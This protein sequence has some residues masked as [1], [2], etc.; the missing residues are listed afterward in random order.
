MY[1]SNTDYFYGPYLI[2]KCTHSPVFAKTAGLSDKTAKFQKCPANFVSLPDSMSNEK[3]SSRKM[4]RQFFLGS[5]GLQLKKIAHISC[6]FSIKF[7]VFTE[8]GKTSIQT[9]QSCYFCPAVFF[10]VKQKFSVCGT[11]VRQ[12]LRRFRE[13]WCDTHV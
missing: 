8:C 5:I 9:K 10:S 6:I 11:A 4:P 7:A 12:H 3:N 1:F 2:C 13:D